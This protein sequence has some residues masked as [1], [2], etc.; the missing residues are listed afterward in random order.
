MFAGTTCHDQY[1]SQF[2]INYFAEM[3]SGSEEGSYSRLLDLRMKGSMY[4][5][6][7]CHATMDSGLGLRLHR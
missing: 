7:A 5:G 2:K 4:A 1:S 6:T 3:R